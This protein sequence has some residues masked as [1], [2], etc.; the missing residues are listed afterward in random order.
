M[1]NTKRYIMKKISLL[2]GLLFALGFTTLDA[3]TAAIEGMWESLTDYGTTIEVARHRSGIRV[4]SVYDQ[5][6]DFYRKRSRREY[7][8]PE[9]RIFEVT[10]S[11][12]LHWRANYADR[13]PV[14]F[15]R[16]EFNEDGYNYDAP[17]NDDQYGNPYN[18][19]DYYDNESRK[20]AVYGDWTSRQTNKQLG[21]SS[22]TFGI[23][24][25]T[26]GSY[27][28]YSNYRQINQVTFR[29]GQGDVIEILG[30]DQ[31]VWKSNN[32]RYRYTYYRARENRENQRRKNQGRRS[33]PRGW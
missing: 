11:G 6:W 13:W 12:E 23:S 1:I 22:I 30:Q 10:K 29:N 18:D 28:P 21:I 24:V 26:N 32:G 27:N 16:A 33:C 20:E 17:Y 7:I 5:E 25:Q 14:K 3:R 19:D 15:R 2:T 8:D 4:K 9:G 31:L